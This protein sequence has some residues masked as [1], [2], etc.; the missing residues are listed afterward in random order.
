LAV[1]EIPLTQG[2]VA[3]VDDEDFEVLNTRKWSAC[4]GGK[5]FYAYGHVRLPDGRFVTE[6]M[7]RVVMVRKLG[8]PLIKGEEVDH[9]DGD[10]LDNRREKLRLA[11][12]AQNGRNRHHRVATVSSRFLG[13]SWS[14]RNKRWRAKIR[15]YDKEVYLGQY[16]SEVEAA[17]AREYYIAAHPELMA[18]SNFQPGSSP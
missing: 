2:K 11:T 10:G 18:R 16:Y 1:K 13:V 3:I 6:T 15:V 17:L 4:K 8:R 5:A 7:H 12:K 14:D 9:D